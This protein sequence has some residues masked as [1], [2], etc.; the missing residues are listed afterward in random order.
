M[1]AL[2]FD[3]ETTGLVKHPKAKDSVQPQIIEWGGVLVNEDGDI[4]AE[5]NTLINP[6]IKLPEKITKITGIT[7]DDLIDAPIFKD[8]AEKIRGFFEKADHVI[9]HNLSFDMDMMKLEIERLGIKDWPW[10]QYNTC[11]VQEH[12]E[13]WGRRPKLT[14]LYKHYMGE[15]LAQTHRALDDV[16]ALLEI[17]IKAGVLR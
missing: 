12:A 16:K 7:D 8:V 9:A 5:Y 15:P 6:G 2:I 14:E 3:T 17:C 13:E 4:I 11:T 1:T 10:P